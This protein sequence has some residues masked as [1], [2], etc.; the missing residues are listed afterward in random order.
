M[1]CIVY[2]KLL[3]PR[4]SFR[5]TPY[6]FIRVYIYIYIYIYIYNSEN[7]SIWLL[8]EEFLFQF[9]GNGKSSK[10]KPPLTS[11]TWLMCEHNELSRPQIL[12]NI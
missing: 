3:K 6:I 1:K 5:T 12:L 2:D 7:V 8:L 9:T 10:I 4:Q 11:A